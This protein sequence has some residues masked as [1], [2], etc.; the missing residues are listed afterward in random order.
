VTAQRELEIKLK[1]PP[2]SVGRVKKTPLIRAL[3]A[4]P[5]RATEIS[6][7]FD[8]D[9]RKLRKN[10]LMLRV[11][12][13]GNHYL[14][15]IK[16]SADAGLFERGEWESKIADGEPDLTLVRDTALKSI[17]NSK[18]RRQLKPMFETRVHRT[19]YP[20]AKRGHVIELAIDQ[21]KI[22]TG[23]GSL[24]LCELELELKRGN[25]ADLF[26]VARE[27]CMCCRPN[28]PSRANR[29]ADMSLSTAS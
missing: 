9:K 21:G 22:D 14:Q 15:T 23:A 7:Y 19:V 13:I 18:L 27:S 10:G 12:R 28:S 8:T 29:S 26:R 6:V 3:K 17:M 16:A 1:L 24:P 25:E 11:R 2:A 5:K 20:I 4:L